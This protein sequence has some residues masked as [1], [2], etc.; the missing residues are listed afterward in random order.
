MID[1][2][3]PPIPDNPS[4]NPLIVGIR[5]TNAPVLSNSISL[6]KSIL[7]NIFPTISITA[8]PTFFISPHR[9]LRKDSIPAPFILE[10][11]CLRFVT[12][13]D[14]NFPR[15]SLTLD[16]IPD[17]F[18]KVVEVSSNDLDLK[19]VLNFSINLPNAVF[20]VFIILE[21]PSCFSI[22][23]ETESFTF[24]N[25]SFSD[26]N[27]FSNGPPSVTTFLNADLIFPRASS[28]EYAPV[29]NP[30]IASTIVFKISTKICSA[31]ATIFAAFPMASV[32]VNQS[33]NAFMLSPRLPVRDIA[34]PDNEPNNPNKG[35]NAV[36]TPFK[37]FPKIETIENTP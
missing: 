9:S 3:I 7:P 34:F 17:S 4:I 31:S 26:P 10:N 14:I 37:T 27:N 12:M 20:T 28:K 11:K 5:D 29:I 15:T 21:R 16:T 6:L 25:A 30:T 36:P 18:S 2:P 23:P 35:D 24:P 8:F 32:F 19:G 13:L 22:N 1:A 33:L